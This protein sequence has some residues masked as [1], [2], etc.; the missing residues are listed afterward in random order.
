MRRTIYLPD[1]LACHVETY[2]RDH[3]G[4]TFSALVRRVLEERVAP[5]D[6]SR[7]LEL[8]GIVKEKEGRPREQPEDEV[9]RHFER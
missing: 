6:L 1:D 7:I 2:L 9:A 3:P 8:A 4:L 5:R